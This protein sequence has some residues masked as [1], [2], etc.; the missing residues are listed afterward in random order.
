MDRQPPVSGRVGRHDG[1]ARSA[2]VSGRHR[3]P[4]AERLGA[5]GLPAPA[6]RPRRHVPRAERRHRELSDRD[7]LGHEARGHRQRAGPR[8]DTVPR[9]EPGVHRRVDGDAAGDLSRRRPARRA[10]VR[11]DGGR[12]PVRRPA[13]SRRDAQHGHA[14][15]VHGLPDAPDGAGAGADG[16]LREP[17]HSQGLAGARAR[18]RRRAGRGGRRAGG[19]DALERTRPWSSSTA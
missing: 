7:A 16:A 19:G 11:R 15:G 8:G 6:R 2:A 14:G 10:A 4:A 12:V 3:R 13:V 17:R 5:G 1:L 18:D 9:P